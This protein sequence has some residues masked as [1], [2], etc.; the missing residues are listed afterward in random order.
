MQMLDMRLLALAK[1]SSKAQ[2]E[3]GTTPKTAVQVRKLNCPESLFFI[4]NQETIV[5][6]ACCWDVAS[7]HMTVDLTRKDLFSFRAPTRNTISRPW[8]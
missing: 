3:A 1:F 6:P 8:V 2:E 5:A 4:Q 7:W